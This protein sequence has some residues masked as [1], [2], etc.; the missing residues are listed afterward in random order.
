MPTDAQVNFYGCRGGP[1]SNDPGQINCSHWRPNQT[2]PMAYGVS[3]S[4]ATMGC[5]QNSS[6]PAAI[7]GHL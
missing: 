2:V 5:L 4:F 1:G 6:Q 7:P 3:F